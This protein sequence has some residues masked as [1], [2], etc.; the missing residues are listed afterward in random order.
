M[1]YNWDHRNRLTGVTVGSGRKRREVRYRYDYSNRLTKRNDEFFVHDGWQIVCSL[2]NDKVVDRYLWG[3]RQDELLCEND[4]FAL[5][6]HLGTVR[7]VIDEEGKI[8]SK[9]D[10]DAFGRLLSVDGARP[11]FRYTA[12]FIDEAT[13]MQWNINRWLDSQAGRWIN[14]DPIGF[15]GK[16]INKY[17]Y[18]SN[19]VVGNSDTN[20]LWKSNVHQTKTFD[21]CVVAAGG[22][23]FKAGA[24]SAIA[25]ANE[26]TDSPLGGT[27]PFPAI[28]D[29]SY[30]FNR[31][32]GGGIDSRLAHRGS[33]YAMAR[34]ECSKLPRSSRSPETAAKHIG[35]GLHAI[36]DFYAH[37]DYG[38]I[39]F[40]VII[41]PHNEFGGTLAGAPGSPFTYP[42]NPDLD[43]VDG[44]QGRPAGPAIKILI[45]TNPS[46]QFVDFD[47][48]VYEFATKRIAATQADT[49]ADLKEFY[50]FLEADE[51]LCECRK[52]F[53]FLEQ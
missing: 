45:I 17:R 25:A 31:N 29:Q 53:T 34:H 38:L 16:D 37:G 6:D 12:K 39:E 49:K 47:Y 22:G 4:N 20:G 18:V 44:P 1:V 43:A 8:V 7:K 33:R 5:A 52:Y 14:E 23:G 28:G 50:D 3:A 26:G 2:K 40:P 51:T 21:W 9:L 32:L 30:H 36:Q 19:S 46:G 13:T 27:S 35:I 15:A 11:R 24:C 41:T 10:Y 42:D 48:A